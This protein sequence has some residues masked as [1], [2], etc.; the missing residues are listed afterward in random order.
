MRLPR[1]TMLA[2]LPSALLS[3]RAL[4]ATP[5]DDEIQTVLRDRIGSDKGT[6]IVALIRD[7]GGS[8]LLA[9]G[10]SGTAR[11]LDGDTVFEIGSITKVLTA[12]L[13]ADMVQRGEVALSDPLTKH[14][15]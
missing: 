10:S 15:P 1:R 11:P 4:T 7:A 3:P 14:L 13:L 8:R 6:G 12:L 5:S 9:S 2:G